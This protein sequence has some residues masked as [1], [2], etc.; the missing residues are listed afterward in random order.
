MNKSTRNLLIVFVVLAVVVYLFFRGKDIQRTEN[1]EEKFFKADSAKI[2]KIEIIKKDETITLEKV[3]GNWMVTKPV[4]YPAD[5]TAISQI[6][7]NLQNYKIE[8]IISS[9]PEKASNR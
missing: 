8:S 3:G 7:S 1:I 9:N 6:L 5:T 2:E 4:N